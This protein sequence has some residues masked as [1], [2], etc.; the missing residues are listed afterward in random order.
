MFGPC[1]EKALSPVTNIH[2][3]RGQDGGGRVEPYEVIKIFQLRMIWGRKRQTTNYP[4]KLD[5]KKKKITVNCLILLTYNYSIIRLISFP[6]CLRHLELCQW[7]RL[8]ICN[9]RTALF[10]YCLG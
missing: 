3:A 8:H 4:K 5:L 10:R 1:W 6:H 9:A 2:H 7:Q